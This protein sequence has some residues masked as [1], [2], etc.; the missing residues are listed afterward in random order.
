MEKNPVP[1]GAY[2]LAEMRKFLIPSYSYSHYR[3][4]RF[5]APLFH[6]W[7]RGHNAPFR[8]FSPNSIRSMGVKFFCL[9]RAA[10]A[11]HGK[12]FER[13]RYDLPSRLLVLLVALFI[14]FYPRGTLS[15]LALIPAVAMIV[16]VIRRSQKIFVSS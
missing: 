12:L 13:K 6:N 14:L 16:L 2:S 4:F 3:I 10:A 7:L 1:D 8:N 5:F 11:I 15:A 9:R